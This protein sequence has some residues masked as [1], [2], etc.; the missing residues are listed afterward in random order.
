[1]LAKRIITGI[2][3]GG[4]TIFIIYEGNWLFFIMMT[5][6][7]LLGWREYV[8][9]LHAVKANLTEYAGYVWLAAV[10][11]AW[12]F[13]GIKLLFLLCVVMMSWILLRTVVCHR[14]VSLSDSAYSLYG[15]LYIGGGFLAMLALRNGML[16]SYLTG[17]FQNV[18]LEPA[19]FFV[20][21]LV[22]STWASD[23]FAFA[24]GKAVGKNKLCP[25]ISPGK[26][27]EGALG[28]CIGTIVVALIF[29][30]IFKFS[31]LHGLA[32][33]LIV[34]IM[35]PLGDLV[36]SVLKRTCGIKDSGNI[37]PGHGGILDRFDS[38][39]FAA[40]AVYAYLMLVA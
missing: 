35:A 25:S 13:A 27:R 9:M 33:G 10:F 21:L 37:I 8:R 6:L 3:G 18:M 32:I 16:A 12:W 40:P 38:L 2:V 17:A 19:R 31:L 4:L 15:L 39:L 5:L 1:M 28:G 34:A 22:F 23:T 20:F 26:T 24:A 36:E 29:S 14:S 11:G 7:A 30:L